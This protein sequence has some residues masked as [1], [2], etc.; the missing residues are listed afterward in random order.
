MKERHCLALRVGVQRRGIACEVGTVAAVDGRHAPTAL[1]QEASEQSTLAVT[2][3]LREYAGGDHTCDCARI[4]ARRHVEAAVQQQTDADVMLHDVTR[5]DVVEIP[6]PISAQIG[7]TAV[8]E[9]DGY[10]CRYCIVITKKTP[11]DRAPTVPTTSSFRVDGSAPPRKA[12]V[13]QRASSGTPVMF[14]T[15][16]ADRKVIL[17]R[18]FSRFTSH[19]A[20]HLGGGN[21]SMLRGCLLPNAKGRQFACRWSQWWLFLTCLTP[22]IEQPRGWRSSRGRA[23]TTAVQRRS[24]L[25]GFPWE[26][27]PPPTPCTSSMHCKTRRPVCASGKLRN[28]CPCHDASPASTCEREVRRYSMSEIDAWDKLL[29][30]KWKNRSGDI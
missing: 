20:S 11:P 30:G 22:R 6:S 19:T 15:S 21:P 17:C 2:T 18:P 27:N 13:E 8:H 24:Y 4:L 25:T 1:L 5:C 16:M 7:R 9:P 23:T 3:T 29:D 10:Y 28:F 26:E 12:S 14:T